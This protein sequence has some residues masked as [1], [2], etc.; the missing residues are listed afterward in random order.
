MLLTTLG[1]TGCNSAEDYID[2]SVK[3]LP[4]AELTKLY[5]SIDS[6]QN[7]YS[8]PISRVNW[9]KWGRRGISFAVD[10]VVGLL[11]AETGPLAAPIGAVGSGLY[12][13]YLDY[14]VNRSNTMNRKTRRISRGESPSLKAVVFPVERATFVDSIGYYHNLI[15]NEVRFNGKSYTDNNG[16]IDFTSFYDD[17]LIV[18]KKHGINNVYPINTRLL[19]QYLES[20][21]KPIALLE[22]NKQGDI[23]SEQ[24]LSVFFNKNYYGFNY[25]SA[26]TIQHKEIVEK[27]IYNCA[28]VT[29]DQLIEYGTKVNN[30]IVNSHI[31]STTKDNLKIANNIAINTCWKN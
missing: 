18:A 27:I 28:N 3:E 2:E 11:F 24:I 30:I 7:V 10:G 31:D 4:N 14:M 8:T 12:E 21:I 16:D 15:M 13:D 25:D 29:D 5:N 17:V 9:D 19:F 20:I 22:V 26:K 6:L 1:L 23:N